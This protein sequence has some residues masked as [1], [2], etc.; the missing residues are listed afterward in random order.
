MPADRTPPRRARGCGQVA[1]AYGTLKERVIQEDEQGWS[2]TSQHVC[3]GCVDDYALQPA[4][5]AAED[6]TAACDFC[7]STPAAELDVL[8]EAFVKAYALNTLISS[9]SS[10][11][12]IGS[13]PG[14]P[15]RRLRSRY[16]GY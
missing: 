6:A 15:S 9:R 11:R 5:G 3:T 12:S 13:L 7:G 10:C 14:C 2:F 8:L 4:T 1:L 16:L